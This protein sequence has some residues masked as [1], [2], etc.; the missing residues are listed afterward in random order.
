MLR[1]LERFWARSDHERWLLIHALVLL[2]AAKLSLAV[3]GFN[4]TRKGFQIVFPVASRPLDG[5]STKQRADAAM[6]SV[7]SAALNGVCRTKCLH[8]SLVLWALLRC[9]GL[10]PTLRFGARRQD[11]VFE[12]HAWVELDSLRL[13]TGTDNAEAPFVPFGSSSA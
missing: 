9:E 3:A 2:P 11:G 8:E 1:K 6:S 7:R 10:N 13:D 4:R 5:P 12:A